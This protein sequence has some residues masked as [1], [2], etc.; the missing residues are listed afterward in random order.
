[1]DGIQ[2]S[3]LIQIYSF[4][5]LSNTGRVVTQAPVDHMFRYVLRVQERDGADQYDISLPTQHSLL[6]L[7]AF[8]TQFV[9]LLKVMMM[10][11][12]D[13]DDYK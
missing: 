2:N 5:I 4:P 9:Y 3:C 1:M 7:F 11:I 13:I 10:M 8:S 6:K 12:N